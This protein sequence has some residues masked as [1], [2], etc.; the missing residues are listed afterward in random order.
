[1]PTP[2]KSLFSGCRW[3][4]AF[5]DGAWADT[6]GALAGVNMAVAGRPPSAASPLVLGVGAITEKA[7][8]NA[9][10]LSYR[11]SSAFLAGRDG[12]STP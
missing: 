2:A 12:R 9:P 4:S 6:G 7:S 3:A 1:M 5:P 11:L 8:E 10:R